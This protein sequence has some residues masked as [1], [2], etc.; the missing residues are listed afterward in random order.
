MVMHQNWRGGRWLAE[1]LN[2][3]TRQSGFV[4][5]GAWDMV[6]HST[7]HGW[8]AHVLNDCMQDQWCNWQQHAL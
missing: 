4:D 7:V 5:A 3:A 8:L 1:M 2:A 6:P